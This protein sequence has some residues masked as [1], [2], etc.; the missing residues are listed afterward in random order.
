MNH[1]VFPDGYLEF[2]NVFLLGEG[3]MTIHTYEEYPQFM[4][5]DENDNLI[6][7]TASEEKDGFFGFIEN[8]F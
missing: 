5:I 8:I 3:E 2:L 4:A 6:A 7:V 1:N